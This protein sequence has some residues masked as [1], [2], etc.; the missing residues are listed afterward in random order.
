M[1]ADTKTYDLQFI[2]GIGPRRAEVLAKSGI[3]KIFDLLNFF[4][5]KYVD[6]SNI[7][8]LNK[9]QPEQEV[10]VIGKIE[11]A[12]IRKA[13][14]PIFYIVISDGKGILEAVWFNAANYFKNLFKVGDWVSLSGKVGFYRGYQL[15]H[16]E[17]DRLGDK[18]IDNL[19]NTGHIIP[20]YPENE[21][22]KRA[23]INSYTFRRAFDFIFN[24]QQLNLEEYFPA[25]ILDK[26]KFILRSKAYKEIHMPENNRL[27]EQAIR[28][29]KYEDFYFMQL[30]FALQRAHLK[31]KPVGVS[32]DKKSPRLEQLYKSLPFELTGAQKNV[33]REIRRDMRQ[34]V[35]MNRLLQGDVGS[36]KTQPRF[37]RISTT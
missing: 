14:K 26:R 35:P 27:L 36:G 12:G 5:R 11:A 8:P 17:Y 28:R 13:R 7:A 23:G 34:S 10:T 15:T 25:A 31:E 37:W 33:I 16:P 18:E 22:F 1:A 4:P 6:R 24:K 3:K 30:M 32:F 19:I 29:F 9:L 2:K 20:F 21:S